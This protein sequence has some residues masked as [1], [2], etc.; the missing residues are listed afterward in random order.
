MHHRAREGAAPVQARAARPHALSAASPRDPHPP[1][2]PNTPPRRRCWTRARTQA[3]ATCSRCSSCWRCAGSGS[4]QTARPPPGRRC[5][6]R[7]SAWPPA[8]G[9]Q[10]GLPEGAV[11]G[12]GL[13]AGSG[14]GAVWRPANPTLPTT[15]PLT[16]HTPSIARSGGAGPG[17][18]GHQRGA[19]RA[20]GAPRAGAPAAGECCAVCC[21]SWCGGS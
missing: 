13:P 9:C 8:G 18:A 4:R 16:T 14:G 1:S 21:A 10:E 11:W 2:P 7:V 15:L 17:P 19:G 12:A 6:S 20:D 3:P 5:T